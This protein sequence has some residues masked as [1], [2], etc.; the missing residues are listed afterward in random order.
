[1][2]RTRTAL[3]AVF[4][5]G[6]LAAQAAGPTERVKF[7]RLGVTDPGMNG[8][9]AVSMLVPAGWKAEGGIQWLPDFSVQANLLLTVSD[10]RT[11]AAVEFCPCRTSHT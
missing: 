7:V 4:L 1:M 3:C 11:G 9:E 2:S 5:F 8:I 10:P 6:A